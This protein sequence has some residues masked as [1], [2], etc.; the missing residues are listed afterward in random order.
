MKRSR[1]SLAADE[2]GAHWAKAPFAIL[3]VQD[4]LL[5]SKNLTQRVILEIRVNETLGDAL[6]KHLSLMRRGYYQEIG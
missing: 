1:V 2:S 5:P 4:A 6:V 3:I